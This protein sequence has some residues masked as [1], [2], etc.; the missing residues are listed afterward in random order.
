MLLLNYLF[1][2]IQE[3]LFIQENV[4][5]RI[6]HKTIVIFWMGKNYIYFILFHTNLL[7]TT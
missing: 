3:K 6:I 5:Q 7:N 2:F 1:I 4:R